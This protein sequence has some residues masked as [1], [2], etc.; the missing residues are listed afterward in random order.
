[1]STSW[2]EHPLDDIAGYAVGALDEPD[3]WAVEAHLTSCARCRDELAAHQEALAHLVPEEEPPPGLWDRIVAALPE[4]PAAP[5]PPPPSLLTEPPA[6]AAPAAPVRGR[7]EIT[8]RAQRKAQP[9]EGPG[10]AEPGQPAAVPGPVAGPAPAGPIP[11]TPGAPPDPDGG[12]AGRSGS[13]LHLAGRPR[14][15]RMARALVGA[16]A[17]VLLVVVAVAA[18]LAVSGDD[19]GDGGQPPDV[20]APAGTEEL[21]RA[22]AADPARAAQ[23]ASDTGEPVARLVSGDEG[24]FVLLDDLPALPVDRAYQLWSVDA[25]QP[26]S[27]G[28]LGDG[29]EKA[30]AVAVPESTVQVAIS[31]APSGG[32]PAPTGPIVA[33]GAVEA[34]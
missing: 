32:E 8:P 23:L 33:T 19:D 21:A 4:Q 31:D 10:T 26:V 15:Q 12:G 13:P 20:A 25:A 22:A 27:L 2:P 6:P 1:M 14:R 29:S 9:P 11:G 7:I 24:T 5:P 16:A 28:V 30:V 34:A 18:T 3:R 17:A